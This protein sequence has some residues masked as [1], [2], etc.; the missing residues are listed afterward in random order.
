MT[1]EGL[2]LLILS[3][4]QT[5][6]LNLR[7]ASDEVRSLAAGMLQSGAEAVLA[8]QWAVDDEAT[9]LLVVRFAQE[10]LP[11]MHNEPPATALARAQRWLRTATRGDL[12]EWY[13]TSF[14]ETSGEEEWHQ[15]GTEQPEIDLWRAFSEQGGPGRLVAVRG[16]GNRYEVNEAQALVRSGVRQQNEH[17][18]CPYADPIYWAGFQITGW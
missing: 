4:C 18:V 3:A 7:E 8:A 5:A 2:R 16:R 14:P 6:I 12:E 13:A 9:Y 10:W 17:K 15:A 11:R 1:I